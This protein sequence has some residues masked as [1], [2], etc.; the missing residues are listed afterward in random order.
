M[1]LPPSFASLSDD[2]MDGGA[3]EAAGTSRNSFFASRNSNANNVP[4]VFCQSCC[5]GM[6]RLRS[7]DALVIPN[8]REHL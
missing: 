2:D 4:Q 1:H 3:K 7:I 6:S 8:Y 5:S